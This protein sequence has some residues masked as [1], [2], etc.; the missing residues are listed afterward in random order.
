M[1]SFL[2]HHLESISSWRSFCAFDVGRFRKDG[3]VSLEESKEFRATATRKRRQVT[4]QSATSN[5]F[6]S[7]SRATLKTHQSSAQFINRVS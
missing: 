6:S 4:S 5:L 3:R 1:F 7:R 2:P